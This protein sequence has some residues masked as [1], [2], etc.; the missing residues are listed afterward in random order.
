M[1][2]SNLQAKKICCVDKKEPIW[3]KQVPRQWY[4]KFDFFMTEHDFKKTL[5]EH[6]FFV[7]RYGHDD[8]IILLLYVD[9]MLIVGHDPKKIFALK[10][11]LSKSFAMK[12]LGSAKQILRMKIIRDR[13][14]I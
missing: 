3:S 11:T 4:K 7:K 1:K 13:S 12:Y 6:S 5:T 2:D 14:K 9:D 8:F 10:K